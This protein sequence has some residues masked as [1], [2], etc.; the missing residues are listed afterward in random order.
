MK[1]MITGITGFAGSHLVEFLMTLEGLEIYGIRRWRRH[2]AIF[3]T[4]GAES[5]PMS[6]RLREGQ[7]A[8]VS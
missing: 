3:W 7:P 5:S 6:R 2:C 4:T 8:K 1:V